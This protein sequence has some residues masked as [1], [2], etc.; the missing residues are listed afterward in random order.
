MKKRNMMLLTSMMLA[1]LLIAGGTFA[2]FT[3]ETEEVTN[4]FT[5][6]TL[7]IELIESFCPPT[8]VN[9]GDCV[10]KD[11]KIKNIGTKYAVVR[12][13]KSDVFEMANNAGWLDTD[14]V[15][16]TLGTNWIEKDGYFIY[17][18]VL[19]TR[20]PGF[21]FPGN[22]KTTS[23][24]K[25]NKVCFSGPDMGNEYQ[26]AEY[27]MIIK[28][29]GIQATN[30][31]PEEWG[32]TVTWN[33][34]SDPGTVGTMSMMALDAGETDVESIPDVIKVEGTDSEPEEIGEVIVI[35]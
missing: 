20:D 19:G 6:G 10:T 2:W 11:V 21:L 15:T 14:V 17:K 7:E 5:A 13:E 8:N 16:Y 23:L 1:V 27:S 26:G 28:G 12:I 31:A 25:N 33:F 24:F 9:P 35:E 18:K 4:V 29:E 34:W 32:L 22:N 30:D 3:A